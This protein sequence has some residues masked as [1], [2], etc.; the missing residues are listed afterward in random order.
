MVA[1]PLWVSDKRRRRVHKNA[2]TSEVTSKKRMGF[3]YNNIFT[4]CA[5]VAGLLQVLLSVVS[6]TQDSTIV[7]PFSYKETAIYHQT[8]PTRQPQLAFTSGPY[9]LVLDAPCNGTLVPDH[10]SLKRLGLCPYFWVSSLLGFRASQS[11][12]VSIPGILKQLPTTN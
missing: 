11:T 5:L 10:Q 7:G 1:K 12:L 8:P 6:Y 3:A 4:L 2:R 9:E